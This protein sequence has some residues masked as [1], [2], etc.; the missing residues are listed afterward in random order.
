[1]FEVNDPESLA[2]CVN[3][4]LSNKELVINQFRPIWDMAMNELTVEGMAKKTSDVY[5]RLVCS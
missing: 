1:L 5:G 3:N 4:V 2:A